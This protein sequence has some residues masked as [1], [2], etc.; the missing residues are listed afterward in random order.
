MGFLFPRILGR[1]KKRKDKTWL[2]KLLANLIIL[3][4]KI[5]PFVEPE[6]PVEPVD[7]DEPQDAEA[8]D[9]VSFVATELPALKQR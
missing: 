2:V 9:D 6:S 5:L 1:G 4:L 3:I 7:P 8:A